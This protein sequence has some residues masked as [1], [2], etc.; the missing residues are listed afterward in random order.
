MRFR[1]PQQC[2]LGFRSSG[3][4]HC[5]LGERVLTFYKT[6]ALSHSCSSIPRYGYQEVLT[7]RHGVTSH[8][9]ID[10]LCYRQYMARQ[11]DYETVQGA[12][13]WDRRLV[14]S[15]WP[16]LGRSSLRT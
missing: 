16:E 14:L 12:Y 4:W 10:V 1:F 3:M 9:T 11:W 8:K 6:V 7:E 2:S 15:A 5:V 13:C